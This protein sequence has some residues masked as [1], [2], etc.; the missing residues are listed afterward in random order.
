MTRIPHRAKSRART[1]LPAA[2]ASL[3]AAREFVAH[4]LAEWAFE[5]LVPVATLIVNVFPNVTTTVVLAQPVPAA[6]S[7]PQDDILEPVDTV[8]GG[9]DVVVAGSDVLIH[10]RG[11]EIE[12]SIGSRSYRFNG[13]ASTLSVSPALIGGRVYV[14]VSLLRRI[15]GK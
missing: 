8:V 14:P 4:Q 7:A 15:A 10:Y 5:D 3:R 2:L 9:S 1:E 6:A 13:R 12:C 11:N